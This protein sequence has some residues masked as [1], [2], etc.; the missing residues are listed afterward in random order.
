MKTI[1]G[2]RR[3]LACYQVKRAAKLNTMRQIEALPPV[4]AW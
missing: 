2:A 1:G 3:Q 4:A